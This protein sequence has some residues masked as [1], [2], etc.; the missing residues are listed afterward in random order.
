MGKII[1]LG[2][3]L[4]DLLVML[5]DDN[6]LSHM[7][8][9]KGAMQLISAT[10]F[11]ELNKIIT[12]KEVY[13]ST[14]GSAA[15]TIQALASLNT[16]VGFIGKIGEDEYGRFFAK[17]FKAKN[18]DCHLICDKEQA[19]GVATTFI[20]KDSERTFGTYLGAAADLID[21]EIFGEVLS[22]YDYLYVEGYLVQN[23]ELI[24]RAMKL[25]K[26][27][28]L[29]IC[30]DLASYNIISGDLSFF[31]RLIKDYVDIVFANEDEAYAFTGTE[32]PVE[33]LNLISETCEIAIVKVGSKGSYVKDKK[34]AHHIKTFQD[35]CV[36]DTTGAGDYY[37]AGFLYG[38]TKGFDIETCGNIGALLSGHIIQVVGANLSESRW[39]TVK[40][41]LMNIVPN[42]ETF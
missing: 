23:H 36:I 14:G 37:A 11:Q 10:K 15:N 40:L 1:G 17:S 3:A 39:D 27:L 9:C 19:S 2:N 12:S 4:I 31:K 7:G 33:A 32:D 20:S 24:L 42:N 22:E 26:E 5:D 21:S 18:I 29:K 35:D 28:G 38:H 25:S 16:P 8:L 6:L 41:N 30:I 34:S 13:M